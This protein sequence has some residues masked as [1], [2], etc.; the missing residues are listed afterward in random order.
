MRGGG[1]ACWGV[2]WA[3]AWRQVGVACLV[4]HA[5]RFH[6]RVAVSQPGAC[7]TPLGRGAIRLQVQPLEVLE[8]GEGLVV[9]LA[10]APRRSQG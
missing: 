5:P 2:A 9:V 1:V 3:W 4:V 7:L 6:H 10:G 8:S